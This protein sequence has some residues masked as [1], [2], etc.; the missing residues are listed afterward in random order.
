MTKCKFWGHKWIPVYIKGSYNGI[1]VKFIACY[2]A[3]CR[4]GYHEAMGIYLMAEDRRF[5]TYSEKYFNE[6]KN[7]SGL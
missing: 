7:E 2:C 5:G 6:D 3:R 1:M 4:K